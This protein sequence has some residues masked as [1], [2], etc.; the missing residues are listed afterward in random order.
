M[1][2][3]TYTPEPCKADDAEALF[4]GEVVL[5]APSYE[6][7]LEMAANPA[8]NQFL[9]KQDEKKIEKDG[10]KKKKDEGELRSDQIKTLIAMAKWSYRFYVKVDIT[11]KSDGVHFNTVDDLRFDPTTS[12]IINDIAQRLST[13]FELGK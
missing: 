8:L 6:D 11:R 12:A 10:K 13:G 2:T 3:V 9:A 4:K 1:H 5:Q 7:R